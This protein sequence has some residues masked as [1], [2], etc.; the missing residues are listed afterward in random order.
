MTSEM[1]GNGIE[2]RKINGLEQKKR[3]RTDYSIDR[4]Q[5]LD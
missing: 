2:V 5:D 4:S 1:Y 3:V